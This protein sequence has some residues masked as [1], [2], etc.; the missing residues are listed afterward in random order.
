MSGSI[1]AIYSAADAS[2]SSA[3]PSVSVTYALHDRALVL[4]MWGSSGGSSVSTITDGT[5]TYQALPSPGNV[6]T[7]DTSGPA[8]FQVFECLDC[9]AGSPTVTGTLSAAFGS[10]AAYVIRCTGTSNAGA[11]QAVATAWQQNA[12]ATTDAVTSG[13][14]TPSS[15]PAFV[16]G[17]AV[18]GFG[19]TLTSGTGWTNGG[20]GTT[21]DSTFGISSRFE[22]KSVASTSALGATWTVSSATNSIVSFTVVITDGGPAPTREQYRYRFRNDDGSESAATSL[23]AENTAV[24]S[25]AGVAVR[26][27]VGI[28]AT[29]DPAAATY[30]LEYK[31]STDST[32][33]A[34]QNLIT[35][36]GA[37]SLGAIGTGATGTTSCAPS[38][39]SGITADQWL[40]CLATGESS[41]A[42]APTMPAGWTQVAALDAGAN[43]F[44]VDTGP[45]GAWLFKKDTVAGTESGTVTV[46]MSGGATN[47]LYASIFRVS[48][49][50]TSYSLA[51]S[52]A[53]GNDATAGTAVSIAASS[54]LDFG[55]NDLLIVGIGQLV[56]NSTSTSSSISATG[57]TFGTLT[58]SRDVATTQGN[59]HRHIIYS[60]PVSSGSGTQAPTLAYTASSASTQATAVFL[61]LRATPNP[62]AVV[63]T[64][65][66][67]ISAGGTTATTAQLTAPSG[68]TSGADF[69]AGE[70]SDDTNPLPSLDLGSGKYTELEWCLSPQSGVVAAGETYQFR[71]TAAGN[72]LDTYTV[73]PQLSLPAPS[74]PIRLIRSQADRY[75]ALL[76]F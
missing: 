33:L 35:S 69:Q 10:R 60:V 4:V 6:A 61:R 27:R 44:G 15:Q 29:L 2:S 20:A 14:A 66:S 49:P 50:S 55:P 76:R 73:T 47:T 19:N 3:V 53:T 43:A 18:D 1:V 74:Q 51:A 42:V 32:Y 9:A 8:A 23:A 25:A 75:G 71:V 16:V 65:S 64:A 13:N 68:K 30:Q 70:I 59:D 67:N 63:L 54:S 38:Y 41:S 22:Y 62:Q 72:P 24:S 11:A 58:L 45:R 5:N 7:F 17:L 46:S 36:N 52:M 28:D 37:V 48:A 40:Y 21:A 34:V 31:K 26:L 39:P 12:A 56:D 57:I